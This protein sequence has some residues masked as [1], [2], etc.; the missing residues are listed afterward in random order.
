[1]ANYIKRQK[2]LSR[3][4]TYSPSINKNLKSKNSNNNPNKLDN[5]GSYDFSYLNYKILNNFVPKNGEKL[6]NFNRITGY[7]SNLNAN[8]DYSHQD[9]GKSHLNFKRS[10]SKSKPIKKSNKSRNIS[11]E[12]SRKN[13][14]NFHQIIN[15]SGRFSKNTNKNLTSNNFKKSNYPQEALSD[16]DFDISEIPAEKRSQSFNNFAKGNSVIYKTEK[17]QSIYLNENI[18]N[19][20]NLI[21]NQHLN[22]NRS[23]NNDYH[24]NYNFKNDYLP[25]EDN[26]FNNLYSEKKE[27]K[28]DSGEIFDKLYS[29]AEKIKLKKMILSNEIY[30]EKYG[31]TFKPKINKN[32]KY[33]VN[34]DFHE[35][36]MNF[37]KTKRE[38]LERLMKESKEKELSII[39][40]SRTLSKDEKDRNTRSVVERLYKKQMVKLKEIQAKKIEEEKKT[41]AEIKMKKISKEEIEFN[42]KKVVQRLYTGQIEK[43]KEQF[44]ISKKQNNEE[45]Q[46][47]LDL[48]ENKSLNKIKI[49]NKK[50]YSTVQSRVFNVNKNKNE[51]AKDKNNKNNNLSP[52]NNRQNSKDQNANLLKKLRKEHKIKFKN[53][54]LSIVCKSKEKN[55]ELKNNLSETRIKKTEDSSPNKNSLL[56]QDNSKNAFNFADSINSNN[57]RNSLLQSNSSVGDKL[58]KSNSKVVKPIRATDFKKKNYSNNSDSLLESNNKYFQ[59]SDSRNSNE[60]NSKYNKKFE[61]KKKSIKKDYANLSP[62]NDQNNHSLLDINAL[63]N[64][65]SF[66]EGEGVIPITISK[67]ESSLNS[68]SKNNA[69]NNATTYNNSNTKETSVTSNSRNNKYELNN[70]KDEG[71]NHIPGNSD[72]SDNSRGIE[73]KENKFKSKGLEKILSGRK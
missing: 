43:I 4:H 66:R 64:K 25:T 65:S 63:S 3:E 59:K 15:K 58:K 45:L 28:S 8:N 33:N 13:S 24:F 21:L 7:N 46:K 62:I 27:N 17:L 6:P 22:K 31:I 61:N 36:D 51:F 56:Q 18:D 37:V 49:S 34:F 16:A 41:E 38:N 71:E 40:K 30:S 5:Y 57:N 68:N 11:M 29:Q 70:I 23:D 19:N 48:I 42:N 54:D 39:R 2:E 10:R 55:F 53:E 72:N 26:D 60:E 73:V 14:Q 47:N 50:N 32:S 20:I 1:M 35:R 67:F 44:N 69:A 12:K 9:A 52:S